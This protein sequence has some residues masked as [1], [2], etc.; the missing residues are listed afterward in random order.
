M[1]AKQ[2]W[3]DATREL[4]GSILHYGEVPLWEAH[5][6]QRRPTNYFRAANGVLAVTQYRLLYVGIE[7]K[8]KL[9]SEDAPAA[10]L[11]SE[12]VND[13]LLISKPGRVYALTAHGL[14]VS[15]NRQREAYAAMPGYETEL[16]SLVVYISRS[17]ARQ[18]ANAAVERLLRERVAELMRRP[19]RY[20]IQRGDALSTI[21]T[22]FGTTP[23]LLRKWNHL[24]SDKI[25]VHDTLL[26]KPEGSL[27]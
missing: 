11:T 13:T 16:D 23:E 10:I 27:P 4:H 26:V 6:Y 3:Y 5:V 18:R 9:A 2:T 22:R 24:S 8:D 25:R 21:A 14:R 19:L 7:P 20:E 15:R 1:D 12:F 17:H